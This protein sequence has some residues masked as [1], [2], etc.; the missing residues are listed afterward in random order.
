MNNPKNE[1]N[2]VEV[3]IR[4]TPSNPRPVDVEQIRELFEMLPDPSVDPSRPF[5]WRDPVRER[6]AQAQR[7]TTSERVTTQPNGSP[8]YAQTRIDGRNIQNH[9][10]TWI[11][12]HGSDVTPGFQLDHIDRDHLDNRVENL[13]EATH[14]ENRRNN[15]RRGIRN[16]DTTTS[17][18]RGVTFHRQSGRWQ[19]EIRINGVQTALGLFETARLAAYVYDSV[20]LCLLLKAGDHGLAALGVNACDPDSD[21][22]VRDI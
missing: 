13:R 20:K 8:A 15:Q 11:L 2:E 9:R 4:Y 14:G 22:T 5:R 12:A 3:P 16:G 17:R 7:K 18:Y 19:S 6:R 10:I 21:I 1:V